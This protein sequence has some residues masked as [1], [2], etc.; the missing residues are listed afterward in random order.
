MNI[1]I[2]GVGAVG[3]YLGGKLA[4]A[5]QR[6]TLLGRASL[7]QAIE[8]QGLTL[9]IAGEEQ[10]LR[11]IDVV[12]GIEDAFKAGKTYDWLAFTMKAYD[13]VPAILE[14]KN[15]GIDN[16]PIVSFQNGIGNEETLR[17]AF[18][19]DYIAAATL[20]TPVSMP[21]PGSVIEEKQRGIAIASDSPAAHMIIE[22][23]RATDLNL[24]VTADSRSLKWSKLL[25]N[26]IGNA[27]AAILDMPPGEIYRDND[28]FRVE[29]AALKEV[30]IVMQLQHIPVIDLPGTPVR[31]LAQAIRWLPASLL[32]RLLQQQVA[33]GRGSKLPSLQAALHAGATRTEIAWLN[34]AVVQAADN[35]KRYAPVNHALALTLADIITERTLWETYRHKPEMLLAAVRVAQSSFSV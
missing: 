35:L 26:I 19:P 15:A 31:L 5:G 1:L 25:T 4:Q 16:I 14:L 34:G 12:S 8:E 27:T 3:C 17:S 2:Y 29:Y 7:Q 28:L 33:G 18:G 20:T 11:Q 9:S 32:R 23:F 24:L 13:T 6:V 30:L 10:N 21:R 22:A